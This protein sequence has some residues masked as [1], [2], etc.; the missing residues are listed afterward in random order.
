MFPDLP[1]N[2]AQAKLSEAIFSASRVNV[3][4]PIEA[5]NKHNKNLR[6]RSNWLNQ[7]NFSSLHF[8]GPGTD[9]T[10]GLADDHEWMGGAS[11]AKNGIICNPNI[12][13]E[14]VFTTPHC[15]NVEG[16]VS[17]TKPLSHQGTLI[18][19]IRVK[20]ESGSITEAHASKGEE[21][22]LKVLDSDKGARRLGEVALV[23][24]SSPISQ[25][26]LLFYNT[27]FD[28][29]AA[30]HIAL[31]QC[32][33]KCFKDGENLSKDEIISKGGNSSMIHI[34]WMI[35]S[36]EINVDGMTADG[37]Q[38]QFLETVNGLDNSN[39]QIIPR[40]RQQLGE[41]T[42][43]PGMVMISLSA[44]ALGAAFGGYLP[45]IS[46]WMETFNISFQKIGIVCG[47]SAVG[48][49]SAP[50]MHPNWLQDTGI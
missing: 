28:E 42:T 25:S 49:V 35:G 21:V 3:D 18:D 44:V 31:G 23:P 39:L 29:N 22:L 9:L 40:I 50:I 15:L 41:A 10:V 32:Y 24:H 33:S 5:W 45:L 2:E 13:S 16:T 37:L 34:D 4:D 7:Q 19:N 1:E 30:S 8:S 27:L 38:F 26:G 14:E 47:A 12:P 20:F 43:A 48:V 17:S 11:L 36:G 46:L 6:E